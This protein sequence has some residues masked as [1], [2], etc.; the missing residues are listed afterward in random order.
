MNQGSDIAQDEIGG[1]GPSP[2]SGLANVLQAA[3]TAGALR[4]SI[5]IAW[6]H[7]PV[8]RADRVFKGMWEWLTEVGG[9]D[10][11]V[12]ESLA[13]HF[14]PDYRMDQKTRALDSNQAPGAIVYLQMERGDYS[15]VWIKAVAPTLYKLLPKAKRDKGTTAPTEYLIAT[16]YLSA[17]LAAHEYANLDNELRK[18][19]P[20]SASIA[21]HL[22]F[23]ERFSSLWRRTGQNKPATLNLNQDK[24]HRAKSWRNDLLAY[25]RQ[26]VSEHPER[27]V[28]ARESAQRWCSEKQ[29]P[30]FDVA[31]RALQRELKGI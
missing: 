3:T 18:A 31:Y 13:Q 23:F 21:R 26:R 29:S 1:S 5:Q 20:N 30:T 2:K 28:S 11:D 9:A 15:P 6:A 8:E 12:V 14:H 27:R 16:L 25:H 4:L 7:E 24:R 19:P 17:Q 22:Y 10:W